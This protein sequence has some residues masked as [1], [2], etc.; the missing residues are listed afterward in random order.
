M[1]AKL[2]LVAKAAVIEEALKAGEVRPMAIWTCEFDD[3]GW[4]LSGVAQEE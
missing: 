4:E 3:L 1:A 2:A